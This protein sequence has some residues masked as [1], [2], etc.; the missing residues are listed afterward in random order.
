M[1][2]PLIFFAITCG[3]STVLLAQQATQ[4]QHAGINAR[5]DQIMGFSHDKTTHHFLLYPDGGAI[6][7]S[8]NDPGDIQSRDQIHRHL[9]HI[10]G[11]FSAGDFNAPM[12]IHAQTPPG[13]PILQKLHKDVSYQFE[14]ADRGA[15]IRIASSNAEAVRAIHDFLR[16]QIQDH[17]TGDPETVTAAPRR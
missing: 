4:S 12:L 6:E 5:G 2:R 15:R 16:F 7:I 14:E 10:T 17:Q 11:M 13:V 8:A 1:K 9:Q 3:L